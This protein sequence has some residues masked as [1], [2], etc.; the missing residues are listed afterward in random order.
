MVFTSLEVASESNCRADPSCLVPDL[1]HESLEKWLGV[2]ALD[3]QVR[4]LL[5]FA[6]VWERQSFQSQHGPGVKAS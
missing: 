6:N 4:N 1:A 5:E 2:R 3:L